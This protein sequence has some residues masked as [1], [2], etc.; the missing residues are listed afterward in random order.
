M[1]E[2]SE[3]D[4]NRDWE[5]ASLSELIDYFKQCHQFITKRRFPRVQELL[6]RTLDIHGEKYGKRL[7]SL[8]EIFLTFK[9]ETEGHFAREEEILFPY[10]HQMEV[11]KINNGTKPKIPV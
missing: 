6:Q 7:R 8:Q 5:I 1:Y 10:I 9:S 3:S 2:L 4:Q 11:Y